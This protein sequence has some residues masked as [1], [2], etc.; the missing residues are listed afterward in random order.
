MRRFIRNCRDEPT[1]PPYSPDLQGGP[2]KCEHE[3]D[4][5]LNDLWLYLLMRGVVVIT[6]HGGHV[7]HLVWNVS[8]VSVAIFMALISNTWFTENNEQLCRVTGL[9]GVLQGLRLALGNHVSTSTRTH[10]R[11][12]RCALV[13]SPVTPDMT[14]RR[15]WW[16][17][18]SIK[19]QQQQQQ[20]AGYINDRLSSLLGRDVTAIH[21]RSVRSQINCTSSK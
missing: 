7:E 8:Q 11:S 6:D 10:A 17:T 9:L 14:R 21:R 15:V 3:C 1:H 12:A 20:P 13:L 18:L 5:S 4:C 19:V 16:M 2:E